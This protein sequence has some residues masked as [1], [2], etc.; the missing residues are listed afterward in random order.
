[1]VEKIV[2]SQSACVIGR[3]DSV[4]Q[5]SG[6]LGHNNPTT[7]YAWLRR[8]TI[9]SAQWPGL[10]KVALSAGISLTP[11]DFIAHLFEHKF[12]RDAWPEQASAVL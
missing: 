6:L 9:P 10:L 5:L 1:M 4:G 11:S 8:G 3:F 2:H 12:V 7:V